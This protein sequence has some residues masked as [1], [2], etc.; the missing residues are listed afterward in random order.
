[1][2]WIRLAEKISCRFEDT[3]KTDYLVYFARFKRFFSVVTTLLNGCSCSR[4]EIVLD[5]KR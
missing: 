5:L 1:M 4:G 3:L 2:G